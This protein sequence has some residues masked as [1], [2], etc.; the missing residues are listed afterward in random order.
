[1]F[2]DVRPKKPNRGPPAILIAMR[3]TIKTVR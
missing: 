2:V 3:R 1:M